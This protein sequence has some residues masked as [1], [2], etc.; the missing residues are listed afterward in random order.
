MQKKVIKRLAKIDGIALTLSQFTI[1][2][3]ADCLDIAHNPE[4]HQPRFHEVLGATCYEI[5]IVLD[6][7]NPQLEEDIA[8]LKEIISLLHKWQT[9]IKKNGKI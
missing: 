9:Q 2:T 1:D 8:I 4:D 5:D 3:I 6:I 7:M